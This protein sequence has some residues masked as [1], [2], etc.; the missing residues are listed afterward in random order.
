MN[1]ED[2]RWQDCSKKDHSTSIFDHDNIYLGGRADPMYKKDH[3]T[4]IFDHDNIQLGGR[5]DPMYLVSS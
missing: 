2:I 4:S 5:V 3:S 1:E